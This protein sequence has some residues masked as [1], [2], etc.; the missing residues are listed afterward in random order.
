VR[1][2]RAAFAGSAAGPQGYPKGDLPEVAVAGRSN[3]G[4]STLINALLGRKA[5]AKTSATPGK[6]RLI[7]FF[8]V[9]GRFH[10]VDLPGYGY[11]RVPKGERAAWGPRIERYLTGRDAL[12]LVVL[13]VDIRHPA[14]ERDHQMVAWL[15][16]HKLPV[17]VVATKRDKLGRGAA[18]KAVAGLE[19]DLEAPVLPVSA[20]KREGL[21]ALWRALD[22]AVDGAAVAGTARRSP[23]QSPG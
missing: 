6:T 18:G 11:A 22:A 2:V 19:R 23:G 14:Q 10:L 1:G 21:A 12:R 8:D 4:K 7:N 3:V 5:L 9:G 13:L 17:L 15:E 16:H 20:R